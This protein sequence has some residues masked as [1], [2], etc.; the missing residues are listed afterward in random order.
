MFYTTKTF[1]YFNHHSCM[2]ANLI[3]WFNIYLLMIFKITN[4]V[5][6]YSPQEN[7][8]YKSP[9]VNTHDY[10]IPNS[11]LYTYTHVVILIHNYVLL[12]NHNYT[13]FYI[14]GILTK[15]R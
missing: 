9:M 5:F 7:R 11:V 12:E 2:H 4:S 14:L 3:V 15:S 1:G 13:Y 10:Y 8:F 6:K